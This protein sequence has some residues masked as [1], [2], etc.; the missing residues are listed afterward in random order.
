[1]NIP[2]DKAKWLEEGFVFQ[3]SRQEYF[4][5]QGPF[6]YSSRP[7]APSLYHP[8]FFLNCSKPWLKPFFVCKFNRKTLADFLFKME[9][10]RFSKKPLSRVF[11]NSEKPSFIEYQEVF[12]QARQSIRKGE[13]QK[14]VPAFPE[15]FTLKPDLLLLL[16]NLFKN[17]YRISHGFLYGA[18]SKESGI[19]GFTPEILFSM[20]EDQISTMALAGTGSHPGPSLLKDR[21]ELKEHDF[22]VQSLQETLKDLVK[23][24]K[25]ITSE[26]VFPP[27]KHLHTKLKGQWIVKPDFEDI[28]KRLHPTPALGGYPKKWVWDWLKNQASQRKRNFFGAPFAFLDSEEKAL[29]LVALRGLEW[30]NKNS[31]I[32]SGGGLI[33]ESLLQKEWRELFLK[34]EQ[35]KSFFSESL[36]I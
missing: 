9:K 18:W 26:I 20:E 5:G 31:F 1:M 11:K 28:C 15:R 36:P 25:K 27:L 17:T 29:C 21:K 8:D 7:Q 22:V 13:I 35:I 23:W 16:Q 10:D 33:C 30:N 19:L 14:V 32:F 6:S 3:Y 2:I 24:D 4:L 12:F 34:R